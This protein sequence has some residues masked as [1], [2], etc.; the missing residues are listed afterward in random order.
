[1]G[2]SGPVRL[3]AP[4]RGPIHT[5]GPGPVHT[6]TGGTADGG[7]RSQW[8]DRLYHHWACTVLH[9]QGAGAGEKQYWSRS[10]DQ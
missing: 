9:V 1:M 4:L 6:A 2:P 5:A 10:T 8:S 7:G 3:P